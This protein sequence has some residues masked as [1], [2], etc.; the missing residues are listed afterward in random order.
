MKTFYAMIRRVDGSE[1]HAATIIAESREQA[2]RS[3]KPDYGFGLRF[4]EM[5]PQ[6]RTNARAVEIIATSF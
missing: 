6:A 5:V 3:Y 4:T 1:F 2:A